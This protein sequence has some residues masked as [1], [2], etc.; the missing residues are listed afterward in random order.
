MSR[1]V[2]S[3]LLDPGEFFETASPSTRRST[4]VPVAMGVVCLGLFGPFRSILRSPEVPREEILEAFPA[5]QYATTGAEV[6]IP[7]VYGIV[8]GTLL[9][10]PV[11]FWLLFA[12][13]FYALSWP[14]AADRGFGRTARL[15]AW[16]YVP[17]LF[18]N[19]VALAALLATIPA[20]PADVWSM[21]LTPP[22][23]LYVS[24]PSP[25]VAFHAVNAIGV[26]CQL[27]SGYLWAHAV[28]AA[29]E[30]SLRQGL[31]V[32]ALP[33]VLTVGPI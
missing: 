28:A 16:G 1:S 13:V 24:P 15:V 29:R 14:I 30:I 26:G 19:L 32:V 18:G 5:V 4:A 27:W 22:G 33:V 8:F 25:G 20:E 21:L 11:L 3:L 7:G 12:A 9:V 17:L 6:S 2:R 31:A 10:S 23:R